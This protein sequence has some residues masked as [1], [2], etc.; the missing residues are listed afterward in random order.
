MPMLISVIHIKYTALKDKNEGGTALN[1]S[2]A[3]Y[4]CQDFLALREARRWS[5]FAWSYSF[6]F[7][8]FLKK[9]FKTES[10]QLGVVDAHFNLST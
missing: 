9:Y 5:S 4:F 7:M 1:H 2:R 10:K 6:G 8:I 3:E